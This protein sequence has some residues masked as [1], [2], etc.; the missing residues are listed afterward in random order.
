MDILLGDYKDTYAMSI[1]NEEKDDSGQIYNV[2]TPKLITMFMNVSGMKMKKSIPQEQYAS[3]SFNDKIPKKSGT[4]TKTGATKNILGFT[5]SE[6][7]YTNDGGYVSVWATKDF[8]KSGVYISM[9][10]MTQTTPIDGFILEIDSKSGNDKVTMKAV[11]FK[12]DH[13]VTIHT[14]QYKSLGF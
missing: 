13:I 1:P 9:L 14:N 10:G 4:L 7:K 2:I 5:C 12:K 8:P 3:I 11:E 6:Y